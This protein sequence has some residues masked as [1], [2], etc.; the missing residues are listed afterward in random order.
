MYVPRAMYSL[1]MS[2]WIVP[3]S[4]VTSDAALF[5]HGEIHREQR[6]S[7]CVD[8]HRRAHLVERKP[9]RRTCMSSS[10]SM[11][12]PTRPTS[13]KRADSPNRCPSGWG[14]RTPPRGPSVPRPAD[15][16]A[17]VRF[18]GRAEPGVLAHGPR[19]AAVHDGCTPR[20]YGNAARVPMSRSSRCPVPS[21]RIDRL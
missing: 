9:A 3:L 11:A 6:R 5:G 20:V 12:T 14:D 10:V 16:E 17:R 1:R 7:G 4:A 19:P 8:R 15:A 13:P 18:G 21:G 2:F